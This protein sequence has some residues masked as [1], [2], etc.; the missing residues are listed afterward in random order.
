M[1]TRESSVSFLSANHLDSASPEQLNT[2]EMTDLATRGGGGGGGGLGPPGEDFTYTP[3]SFDQ[4]S[5]QAAERRS[6]RCK[7]TVELQLAGAPGQDAAGAG[8]HVSPHPFD[9]HGITNANSLRMAVKRRLQL[10]TRFAVKEMAMLETDGSLF[11]IDDEANDENWQDMLLVLPQ[12]M[13]QILTLRVVV[14]S[15]TSVILG[16]DTVDNDEGKDLPWEA[17]EQVVG[18]AFYKLTVHVKGGK[19]LAALDRSGTSDP[20]IQCTIV[21]QDGA[22]INCGVDSETATA[23][24]GGGDGGGDGGEGALLSGTASSGIGWKMGSKMKRRKLR[25]QYMKQ[26]SVKKKNNSNPHWDEDLS[27]DIPC[28]PE[29]LE[30]YQIKVEAFDYNRPPYQLQTHSGDPYCVMEKPTSSTENLPNCQLRAC[31]SRP[32]AYNAA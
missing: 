12:S 23:A 26:T 3:P 6:F 32:L 21:D 22:M 1:A 15:E 16:A 10:P 9:L 11:N 28:T 24:T 2:F 27:Y 17:R 7:I 4:S 5:S 13:E 14:G 8:V 18:A 20:F 19:D 29:E 31:T 30:T 25:K